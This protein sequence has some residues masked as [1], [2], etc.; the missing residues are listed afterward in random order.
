MSTTTL[1]DYF[2]VHT[3]LHIVKHPVVLTMEI[4]TTKIV[5][6]L[7]DHNIAE[8]STMIAARNLQILNLQIIVRFASDA[9]RDNRVFPNHNELIYFHQLLACPALMVA[10][11]I[12][13]D[14]NESPQRIIRKYIENRDDDTFWQDRMESL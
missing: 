12:V 4:H 5:Y 13:Q 10:N 1:E 7:E 6:V 2:A 11:I 9:I 14:D 8:F 3:Q